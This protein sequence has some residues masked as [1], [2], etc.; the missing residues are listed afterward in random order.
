M[1]LSTAP[2]AEN[3]QD[4]KRGCQL[5]DMVSVPAM[6]F[7]ADQTQTFKTVSQMI[8]PLKVGPAH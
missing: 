5:I 2:G 7:V 1:P 8:Q 6:S 3:Y 4:S